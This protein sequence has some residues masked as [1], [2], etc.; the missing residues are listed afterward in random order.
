MLATPSRSPRNH[1]EMAEG[2]VSSAIIPDCT[3]PTVPIAALVTAIAMPPSSARRP[4]STVSGSLPGARLSRDTPTST[5]M[6]LLAS[7]QG[8]KASGTGANSRCTSS[9]PIGTNT[10]Q[11]APKRITPASAMPE[12][13]Q[14]SATCAGPPTSSVA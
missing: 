2:S 1:S 4:K 9:P 14:N 6:K 3:M 10:A 5:P 7:D 11:R 8:R 13:G 12:A